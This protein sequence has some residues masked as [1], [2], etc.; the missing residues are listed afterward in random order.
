MRIGQNPVKQGTPA[1]QPKRLG[2]ATI[3]Y[4]PV[5]GG[6]FAESLEIFRYQIASLHQNTPGEFDLLV[7]DNGSCPEV[8]SA[9][10]ELHAQGWITWLFSATENLGKTG[11]LN[12]ILPAMPN[13]LVCYTDSDVIFR[14]GWFEASLEILEKFPDVGM[15]T[16][17]P[18]IHYPFPE[19]RQAI[20]KLAG[21]PRIEQGK[22]RPDPWIV[23]EF[24]HGIGDPEG[25]EE[26]RDA[27][28]DML[29]NRD[30]GGRAVVGAVHM[31]FLGYRSIL[32]KIPRLP[33]ALGLHRDQTGRLDASVDE[34][35]CLRLSTLTP[36]VFHAGNS[37]DEAGRA[38]IAREGIELA[39]EGRGQGAALGG[40]KFKYRLLHTLANRRTLRNWMVRLYTALFK[41]LNEK[42]S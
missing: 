38:M 18:A 16:A 24:F 33:A 10:Q 42:N 31:Q 25:Q 9:L 23:D 28:L 11:A 8:K 35:G 22:Y 27:S 4:I 30:N 29:V 21:S 3:L 37:L 14:K 15:V 5:Q 1:S 20:E 39:G 41:V 32:S 34:L 40:A 26:A 36:F 13:E 7:F 17:Q 12:F 2:I 19:K 6:Y